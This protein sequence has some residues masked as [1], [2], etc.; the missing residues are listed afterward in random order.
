MLQNQTRYKTEAQLTA[1]VKKFLQSQEDVFFWKASERFINGVSDI[2]VCC[3]GR[4]VALELKAEGGKPSPHQLL[5]IS[6]VEA[7]GGIGG[8]CYC[9]ADVQALLEKARISK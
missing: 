1:K 2:I 7:K 4:F 6:K 3:K 5:F 9:L 8:V